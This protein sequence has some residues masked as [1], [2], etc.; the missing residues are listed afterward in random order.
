MTN[1]ELMRRYLENENDE[2]ALE[3]LYEKNIGLIITIA[4]DA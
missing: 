1:E 2:D 4:K 3:K